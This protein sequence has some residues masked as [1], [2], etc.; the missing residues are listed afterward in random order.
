MIVGTI[1]TFS[2]DSGK[3]TDKNGEDCGGRDF[4]VTAAGSGAAHTGYVQC[5]LCLKELA[6]WENGLLKAQS[7]ENA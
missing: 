7:A 1:V 2:G 3:H 4:R 6:A 5:T